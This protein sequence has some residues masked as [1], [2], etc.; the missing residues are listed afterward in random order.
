MR[1]LHTADW[2]IGK[3]L[4]G[5]D[6]LADQMAMFK[7]IEEVAK[8][9]KVDAIVI[10]GDLFDRSVP[11]EAAVQKLRQM[12]S[13]LNLADQFPL[14]AISGNHDSAPRLGMASD[15]Y[16]ANGFHLV[17]EFKDAFQPVMIG[18]T[19]FFLL[20]FFG[21]QTAR[22][23]FQDE[24]LNDI[25]QIMAKVVAAMQAQ[26]ASDKHHVLIAHFFAAGSHRTADSETLAE[27]GGLSA[28]DTSLLA[29]FDYVA[30]GHLHNYRAL[31]E[32]RIKYSGSPLKLSA[33]EAETEKG[34]WIV[35]TEP[36]KVRWHPLHQSPEMIKKTGSFAE[37]TA[38]QVTGQIDPADYYLLTLT[39]QGDI[40][41]VM[42]KLREYYPKILSLSWTRETHRP[43]AQELKKLNQLDPLT[44][45]GDF[46]Q[47]TT[48]HELTAQQQAW[49]QA[50]LNQVEEEN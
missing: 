12:L 48:G 41:D 42:A 17:T 24:H 13:Q 35:D 50:A 15:W 2:H 22:N 20:P 9:E 25:N 18:D 38:P 19:Q 31:L 32:D 49:A 40:P 26:F 46:Y 47:Q 34:V 30:L 6:L 21:L 36:F 23:Y 39:D 44:L 10:A 43:V 45:L 8:A 28:V 4:N 27:V 33:S 1:F 14:L 16:V 37:L 5:F 11:S 7:Q 29:P 3:R